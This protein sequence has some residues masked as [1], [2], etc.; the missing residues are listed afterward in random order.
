[1]SVKI[2]ALKSAE[3]VETPE[4]VEKKLVFEGALVTDI[5]TGQ[6]IEVRGPVNLEKHGSRPM[7]FT[8]AATGEEVTAQGV[9]LMVKEEDG[10]AVHKPLNIL[11]KRLIG[12]LHGDLESGQYL[13]YRYH[14][15]AIDKP[16]KTK[17]TV[18]R[19]P[20]KS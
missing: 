10:V 15:T 14:I 8:H 20:L 18:T 16:P 1:M 13:K 4:G 19:E 6:E 11:S 17:Y 3:V 5:T 12:A 7:T 2:G 9:T